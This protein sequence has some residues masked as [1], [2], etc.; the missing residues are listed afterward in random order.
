[1]YVNRLLFNLEVLLFIFFEVI[2]FCFLWLYVGWVEFVLLFCFLILIF[3][4]VGFECFFDNDIELDIWFE[5]GWL[6]VI[7]DVFDVGF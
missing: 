1:M 5:F 4:G 6:L 2:F 7:E 3:W